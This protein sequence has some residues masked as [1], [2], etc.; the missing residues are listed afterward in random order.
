[1]NNPVVTRFAPSPTGFLHIGGARTALFNW[2]YAK[3]KN[4][5]FLLRVEDTDSVRSTKEATDAIFKGLE[6]LGINWDG[7]PIFQK[8]NKMRHQDIAEQLL[9]KGMAYRCYATQEEIMKFQEAAKQNGTSTIYKSPWRENS[10]KLVKGLKSVVRLRSPNIG[11]TVITDQIKGRVSWKNDTLD[12]LVLLRSDGTPTY[13]LA[14]VVDDHDM[15]VSHIIRGDDHLTNSARQILI[16]KAMG[17]NVPKFAHLPLI[18]GEDGSK[19]SKRHG[20][21]SVTEYKKMGY[22]AIAIKNYLARLGWS[23]GDTEYFTMDEAIK[24]FSLEKIGQSPARFDKKKLDSVSKFHLN[25]ASPNDLVEEIIAFSLHQRNLIINEKQSSIFK[26]SINILR[27]RSST[28]HEIIE[29]ARFFLL[30]P[31]IIVEPTDRALI[32]QV[33]LKMLERL[34]L[35]LTAVRWTT[36]ALEKLLSNF[37]EK[38]QIT[39]Q[40]VARP[41]RLAIIGRKS[42]PSIALVLEI[43][44]RKETLNRISDALKTFKRN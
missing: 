20:A 26:K 24:W 8:S 40:T 11:E 6:W 37:V 36:V 3:S 32:T 34:T 13:M 4:G 17:W 9:K 5:K 10:S 27:E 30:N 25:K 31:P 29:N 18:N 14:V 38:E 2:L 7:D 41:L 15:G 1:M 21:V 43:L 39:F 44:G 42:S 35:E 12:D 16:Y 28:F 19:L 33:D 23:H 22:P